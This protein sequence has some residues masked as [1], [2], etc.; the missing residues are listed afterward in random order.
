LRPDRNPYADAAAPQGRPLAGIEQIPEPLLNTP[1]TV[2]FS[3]EILE[4][5]NATTL[6]QA[7]LSR[8]V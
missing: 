2:R 8:P 5:K 7:V 6:K 3:K 4:D 1:K